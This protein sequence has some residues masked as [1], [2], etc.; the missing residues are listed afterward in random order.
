LIDFVLE[1][2]RKAAGADLASASAFSLDASINAGPVT[3][4]ELARLQPYDNTL[5]AVKIT[6]KQLRDYLEFSSRYYKSVEATPA[7]PILVIDRQIPGY[8]FDIIAGAD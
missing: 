2:E 5:R 6:G 4:A 1:T 8:N 7:G 3:V